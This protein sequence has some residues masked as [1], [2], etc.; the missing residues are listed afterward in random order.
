[1][2]AI[3]SGENKIATPLFFFCYLLIFAASPALSI[4]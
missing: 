3:S 1:M 4:I 2:E